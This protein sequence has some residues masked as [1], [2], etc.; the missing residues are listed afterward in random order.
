[1]AKRLIF[2]LVTGLLFSGCQKSQDLPYLPE[3]GFLVL[4]SYSD[5]SS[6]LDKLVEVSGNNDKLS[7]LI[8]ASTEKQAT[9]IRN[10]LGDTNIK[11]I[12]K[13]YNDNHHLES[14]KLLVV[15]KRQVQ[16]EKRLTFNQVVE[17]ELMLLAYY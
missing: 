3:D 1:M 7:T 8:L 5:C 10:Q 14:P 4:I 15:E 9:A 12:R 2:I 16:Y 11:V 6:C 17:I 13:D